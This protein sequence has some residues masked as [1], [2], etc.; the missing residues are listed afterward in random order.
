MTPKQARRLVGHHRPA[1]EACQAIAEAVNHQVTEDELLKSAAE[2]KK[3]ARQAA[4][5]AQG[6]AA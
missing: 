6:E 2:L 4:A 3:A 5:V 1:P